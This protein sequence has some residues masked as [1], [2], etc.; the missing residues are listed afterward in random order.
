MP[1]TVNLLG[2]SLNH[3]QQSRAT[4]IGLVLTR[5]VEAAIEVKERELIQVG[6]CRARQIPAAPA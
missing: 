5:V 2:F 6:K 3:N 4:Q 1:S